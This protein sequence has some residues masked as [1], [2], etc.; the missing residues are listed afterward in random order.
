MIEC[1][2]HQVLCRWVPQKIIL[3]FRSIF[4]LYYHWSKMS[5][6]NCDLDWERYRSY[7][8]CNYWNESLRFLIVQRTIFFNFQFFYSHWQRWVCIWTIGGL[9]I[10]SVL[11][12]NLGLNIFYQTVTRLKRVSQKMVS[13]MTSI[14]TPEIVVRWILLITPWRARQV[15]GESSH[16]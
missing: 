10:T 3:W 2:S 8:F 15:Y 5:N 16:Y 14:S 6:A 4:S 12:F 1:I 9:F 11:A 7:W 13:Q